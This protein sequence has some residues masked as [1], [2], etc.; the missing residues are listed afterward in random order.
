MSRET[1]RDMQ[2]QAVVSGTFFD[3]IRPEAA[4]EDG[5][6][7]LAFLERCHAEF[8]RQDALDAADRGAMSKAAERALNRRLFERTVRSMG[9]AGRLEEFM[10]RYGRRDRTWNTERAG[11]GLPS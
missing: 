1:W 9:L 7:G 2:W 4:C 6:A 3:V 10:D 5:G 8:A 11:P